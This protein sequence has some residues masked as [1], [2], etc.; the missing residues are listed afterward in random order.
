MFASFWA[1]LMSLSLFGGGAHA[2][3]PAGGPLYLDGVSATT[4]GSAV[5]LVVQ[6]NLPS[7]AYTLQE[8]GVERQDHHLLVHLSSVSNHKMAAQVLVPFSKDVEVTG[9]ESG[10]WTVDVDTPNG[11][12]A[13]ATFSIRP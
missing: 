8:P 12:K 1:W 10:D 9:L 11:Q 3:A 5:H 13:S 2:A 4:S 7:P 6:G